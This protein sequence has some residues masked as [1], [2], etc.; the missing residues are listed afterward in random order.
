M[1]KVVET[2]VTLSR[3]YSFGDKVRVYSELRM[4]YESI[5]FRTTFRHILS[6]LCFPHCFIPCLGTLLEHN[7]S[8]PVNEMTFGIL[9]CSYF[10]LLSFVTDI[11]IMIFKRL[12]LLWT[13]LL[14]NFVWN[15]SFEFSMNSLT[16]ISPFSK[17]HFIADHCCFCVC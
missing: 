12:S 4:F 14:F 5:D 3:F 7:P 16:E 2:N 17:M 11:W 6:Y 15:N 10:L 1:C 13:W 8:Y 9:F